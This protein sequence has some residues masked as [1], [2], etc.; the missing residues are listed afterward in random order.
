MLGVTSPPAKGSIK[1]LYLNIRNTSGPQMGKEEL[2]WVLPLGLNSQR[3]TWP[4]SSA[5]CVGGF[6][7]PNSLGPCL[8]TLTHVTRSSEPCSFLEEASTQTGGDL[9]QGPGEGMKVKGG[10]CG[11]STQGAC[12]GP[13]LPCP[14]LPL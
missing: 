2:T 10:E 4:C 12:G 6:R 8:S 7:D 3:D 5:F 13:S 11:S 14:A 9:L 1:S